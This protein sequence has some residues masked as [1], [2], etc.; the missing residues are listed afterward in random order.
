MPRLQVDQDL[1]LRIVTAAKQN[2]EMSQRD[3]A[4]RF[5]VSRQTIAKALAQEGMVTK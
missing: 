1:V 2:P 3:L 5:A 4:K